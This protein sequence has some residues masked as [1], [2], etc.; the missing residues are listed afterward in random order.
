MTIPTTTGRTRRLLAAL[1]VV[2]SFGLLAAGCGAPA[3]PTTTAPSTPA[4]PTTRTVT[5]MEGREVEL[6]GT[7]T[8]VVT[9]GSVPVINSFL[10][11]LG[12]GD[13]IGN[14]L[15]ANF[16]RDDR[17]K[18]QYV[19]APQ[20]ET[21][22]VMQGDGSAPLFE[23]IVKAEPDVVLTMLPAHAEQLEKVG[24]KVIV[25][26]WQND[27]DV[28][29]VV[30]ML[31]EALGVEDRAASYVTTFD[32]IL[33]EVAAEVKDIPDAERVTAL[34]LDP[35]GMGQPHAIAQWWIAKAG[36]QA[37]TEGN[38][39]E[40]LKFDA[41]QVVAWNPQVIFVNDAGSIATA[42]EE[43][44]FA[45]VSAVVDGRV[46]AMPIGAHLWGNRTSEQPLS[47]AYAAANMYPD[48]VSKAKL[49]EWA[50]RFYTDAFHANLTDAQ[51]EDILTPK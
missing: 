13:L 42:K 4:A 41:E 36:G 23:E 45:P 17:W 40:S 32:T 12:K 47:V 33:A 22:P 21:L 16:T 11:A 6:P 51:I 27:E 2:L 29:Q 18:F 7:V 20:I 35:K 8:K 9:L 48:Q 3:S 30:T 46:Y 10:F 14:G 38:T 19:F 49:T 34:S 15:P 31:G 26:R 43:P 25:L 39:V 24:L 37:V 1:T 50:K 44:K 5:D 28:K